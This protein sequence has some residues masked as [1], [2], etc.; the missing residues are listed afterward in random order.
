VGLLSAFL[1]GG[2]L[3]P[4]IRAELEAEGL[5]MLQEKVRGSIRYTHFKAPGKRFHGKVVPMRLAIGISERR[6][7][8]YGGLGAPEL[9]DSPF[10]SPRFEAVDISLDGADTVAFHIDYSRMEEAEAAGVSGEIELR[11]KPANPAE[12]VEQIR[13]RLGR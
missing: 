5:V 13:S 3:K 8:V 9:V 12:I 11:M 7:V 10:D 2:G 6:L 4:K 1:G